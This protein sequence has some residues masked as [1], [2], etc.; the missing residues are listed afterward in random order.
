VGI[1]I[2]PIDKHIL[3]SKVNEEYDNML[4]FGYGNTPIEKME[5]GIELL[6]E[7]INKSK[8]LS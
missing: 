4:I 5:M 8:I 2:S 1:E 3:Y 7:S 6:A